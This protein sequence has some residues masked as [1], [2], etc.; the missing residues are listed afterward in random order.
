MPQSWQ[1]SSLI[2][3]I[4]NIPNI[5]KIIAHRGASFD[6]PELSYE[7][8]MGALAQGA[9]GFE[10]DIRLTRDHHLVL[11]HDADMVRL[12]GHKGKISRMRLSEIQSHSPVMTLDQL[13]HIAVNSKRDLFLETKHPVPTGGV[14]EKE[15]ITYLDAYSSTIEKSGI[16]IRL[17]SFSRRAIKRFSHSSFPSMQIVKDF[18]TLS[19]VKTRDVGVGIF[20][21]RQKPHLLQE[22]KSAGHN[23]HVWTVDEPNDAIWLQGQGVSSI[24][25]NRPAMIRAALS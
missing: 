11:W 9:D 24:I 5:P 21:L 22:L 8:Y 16:S 6:F 7:A 3:N 14:V 10:C 17:M 18:R 2:P 15:I 1:G 19:K 23:I 20:L 12:A 4:L 13:F 25:T